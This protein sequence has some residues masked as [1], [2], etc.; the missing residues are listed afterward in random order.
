MN[1]ILS[2]CH[3]V[4]TCFSVA[5]GLRTADGMSG[6]AWVRPPNFTDSGTINTKW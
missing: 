1:A 3:L 5:G 4:E 2:Q 6:K